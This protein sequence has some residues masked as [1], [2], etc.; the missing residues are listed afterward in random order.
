MEARLIVL[1][2]I[3][4]LMI[5]F[6][7]FGEGNALTISETP[8]GSQPDSYLL[9]LLLLVSILCL[10]VISLGVIL[11]R[12]NIALNKQTLKL[13]AIDE[14]K[15]RFFA[16]ISH[17]LRS[18]MTL[19]SGGIQQV[20]GNP[21]V[22]LNSQ[23]ERLLK[24]A[25]LN[26]ERII[27]MTNEINELVKLEEG[28][29]HLDR[30]HVNVEA[31]LE[32]FRE[33]FDDSLAS[34][35]V[36]INVMNRSFDLPIICVDPFYFEKVLF[37]LISNAAKHTTDGDVIYLIL[38]QVKDQL[39]ISVTDTGEGIAS[40]KLHYIF[41]RY[42]QVPDK[43]YSA[44]EGVGI[45]LAL[46]KEIVD[47]HGGSVE[48][49]SELGQGATFVVFLPL[50]TDIQ[51]VELHQLQDLDSSAATKKL[52][53]D[54]DDQIASS[55]LSSTYPYLGSQNKNQEEF[56][57]TILIVEDHREV[58]SYIEQIVNTRYLVKVAA[59]GLQALKILRRENVD[60][61]ITDL[62]MP[63]LD[64]FELLENL[65]DDEALRK[66]PALVLSARISTEDKGKVLRQG[67]NDFMCKP[68]NPD[69]LLQRIAN[70]LE[71]KSTWNNVESNALII[72]NKDTLNDIEQS[73]LRKVE[74]LIHKKLDDPNLSISFLASQ[75]AVSERK[76][77]RMIKKLTNRTPL[78]HIKE[79]RL[80]MA[81]KLIKQRNFQSTSELAKTV[82]MK[83]VTHFNTHFKKRFGQRPSEMIHSE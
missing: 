55:E 76:Y 62:M 14:A 70:L 53:R 13:Q 42:Y 22:F 72:N 2:L 16:N 71:K 24:I 60:L 65:R 19:I 81:M 34:R 3:I 30:K 79:I 8:A 20:L 68:F 66:I 10:L 52:F 7:N 59:N 25:N 63:W 83:N 48:V 38:T 49:Y 4:L 69:E 45:G 21:D 47:M 64:G 29:V 74:E 23:A 43:Q 50:C 12:R 78:E 32:M 11:Y 37:N 80:Q 31:V 77:F 26:C 44:R 61:V 54:I 67:V 27:H 17:D 57:Q 9:W 35:G 40:D 41:D 36:S 28:G 82:G 18:P 51:D 58:R 6:L 15:S 73:L 46:V 1:R 56:D 75:I 5:C 33:M 39:M